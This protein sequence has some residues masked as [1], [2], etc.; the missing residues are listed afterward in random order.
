MEEGCQR[1]V[2]VG[3]GI[4]GLALAFFL[5]HADVEVTVLERAVALET[6]RQGFSLTLQGKRCVCCTRR[7]C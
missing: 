6:D 5:Q 1:I 7:D 4:A 3:A 2:V